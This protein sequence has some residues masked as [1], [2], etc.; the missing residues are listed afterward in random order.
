MLRKALLSPLRR[1]AYRPNEPPSPATSPE[2]I[3]QIFNDL[4]YYKPILAETKIPK[5]F[6]IPTALSFVPLVAG[7]ACCTV[8]PHFDMFLA[9]LP[10]VTHVAVMYSAL[11][12]ALYAGVHWGLAAAI[13]DPAVEGAA[14][15][16]NRIQ[17]VAATLG[18]CLLWTSVC[19]MMLFPYSHPVYLT[20]LS[21]IAM[22]HFGT[23]TV[24]T[25]YVR[26]YKTVP[27]WYRN[28]KMYVSVGAIACIFAMAYGCYRF[29][30]KTIGIAVKK[31]D[32]SPSELLSK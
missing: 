14:A 6:Y 7:A 26:D 13:Y 23:L 24:D 1:F 31:S 10:D 21:A 4:S 18:P 9:T 25:L 19:S 28:Y 17:F 12:C 20:Q 30:E 5:A 32:K 22:V 29:P 3:K 8:F 27:L 11:H 2:E 16:R 15:S